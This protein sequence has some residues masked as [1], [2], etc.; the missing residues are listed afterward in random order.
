MEQ[1]IIDMI[2]ILSKNMDEVK[3]FAID[4]SKKISKIYSKLKKQEDNELYKADNKVNEAELIEKDKYDEMN[5]NDYTK[6]VL[7]DFESRISI[8][9][10]ENQN[11]RKL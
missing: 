11:Y 9:E 2:K 6:I 3:K 4:D 7:K 10:E 1:D 8:L 5:L